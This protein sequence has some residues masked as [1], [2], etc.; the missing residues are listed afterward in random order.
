MAAAVVGGFGVPV[1]V[2]CGFDVAAVVVC[3]FDVAVADATEALSSL[4]DAVSVFDASVIDASV[5]ASVDVDASVIDASRADE[6]NASQDGNVELLWVGRT[7]RLPISADIGQGK[8]RHYFISD[9]GD[10]EN[11]PNGW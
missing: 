7:A 10:S 9:G 6:K 8:I 1:A 3:G 4:L 11:V 2:V 5:D